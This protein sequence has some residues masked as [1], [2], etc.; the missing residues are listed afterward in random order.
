MWHVH[1][2]SQKKKTSKIARGGGLEDTERVGQNFKK[3][4][5]AI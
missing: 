4:W 5:Q 2:F 1:P 3:V